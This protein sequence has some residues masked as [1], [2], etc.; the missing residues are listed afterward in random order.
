MPY[1][2]RCAARVLIAFLAG[3][4]CSTAAWA[5]SSELP[6]PGEF[7]NQIDEFKQMTGDWCGRWS[8]GPKARL[9]IEDVKA[10]G[11]ASGVYRI[12]K[13]NIEVKFK[14]QVN[15][16]VL[17]IVLPGTSGQ[18]GKWVDADVA[19]WLAREDQMVGT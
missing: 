7:A 15:D 4:G 12:G 6:P 13:A 1:D 3:V 19:M 10:D 14:G 5:A 8:D 18:G 16:H 2:T 17:H 11:T 9:S